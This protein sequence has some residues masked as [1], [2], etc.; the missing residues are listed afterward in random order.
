MAVARDNGSF[1]PPV[2]FHDGPDD[3]IFL[4]RLLPRAIFLEHRRAEADS[5]GLAHLSKLGHPVEERQVLADDDL[6]H[7]IPLAQQTQ[8]ARRPLWEGQSTR[9]FLE[10]ATEQLRAILSPVQHRL[11]GQ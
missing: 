2:L 8:T 3:P 7:R 11:A 10:C 4:P 9:R 1:Q 6:N 5:V